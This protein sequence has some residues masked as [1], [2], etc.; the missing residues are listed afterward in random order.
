[1]LEWL[2]MPCNRVSEIILVVDICESSYPEGVYESLS[3]SP[4]L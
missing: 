2:V 3:L 1:M 4:S